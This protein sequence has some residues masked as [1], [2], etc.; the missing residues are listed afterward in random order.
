MRRR[1]KNWGQRPDLAFFHCFCALESSWSDRLLTLRM[2][3]GK[4][5]RPKHTKKGAPPPRIQSG[6]RSDFP[7][8]KGVREIRLGIAKLKKVELLSGTEPYLIS[9]E[10]RGGRDRAGSAIMLVKMKKMELLSGT[11]RYLISCVGG[12]VQAGS[13]HGNRNS[14]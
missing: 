2:L 7:L 11:E 1:Q 9:C 4:R 3:G 12:G 10:G 8:R 14:F 5:R 13:S 6:G